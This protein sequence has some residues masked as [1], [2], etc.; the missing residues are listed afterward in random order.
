[1]GRGERGRI[2]QETEEEAGRELRASEIEDVERRGGQELERGQEHREGE[3]AHQEE[4][5]GEERDGRAGL[6]NGRA[7]RGAS[8][9]GAPVTRATARASCALKASGSS[10]IR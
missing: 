2:G 6:G 9:W 8:G 7:Q 10:R 1:E 5:P 3:P 4:P